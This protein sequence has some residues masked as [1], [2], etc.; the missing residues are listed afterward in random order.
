[1]T[2]AEGYRLY[3]V[4]KCCLQTALYGDYPILST[5]GKLIYAVGVL[6]DISKIGLYQEEFQYDQLA[7]RFLTLTRRVKFL[8]R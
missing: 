4:E 3:D 2:T 6:D 8:V 5:R 7:P 1:M